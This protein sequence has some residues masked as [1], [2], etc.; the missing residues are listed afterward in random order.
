[1]RD[2]LRYKK[3]E[4]QLTCKN[5]Q[6][7]IKKFEEKLKQEVCYDLPIAFW[8]RKRHEVTL[9]YVKDFKEKDIPT[10]ARPIQMNQELMDICKA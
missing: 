9:P 5:I 8:H 10:K 6:I 2:D 3:I 1:M 4:E 7:E